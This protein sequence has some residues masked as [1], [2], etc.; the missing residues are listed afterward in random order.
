M[1]TRAMYTFRSAD[2]SEEHHVYVH[3]D[4]YPTGAAE[5][6]VA[7]LEYAWPLPRYEA[8]EFAAAFVAANKS[9]Y[10]NQELELLRQ[11][12]TLGD[13]RP[14]TAKVG[15]E[16]SILRKRLADVRR[17]H[18]DGFSGGGVRLM[19][20]GKFEDVAPQDL[21]YRYIIQ[22]R[23]AS[24]DRKHHGAATQMDARLLVHAFSVR[25]QGDVEYIETGKPDRN[26]YR[27]WKQR[28]VPKSKQ[29][30]KET[31]LFTAPLKSG[32]TLK[33]KAKAWEEADRKAA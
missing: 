18:K 8:D 9:H 20:S 5:K 30:W 29:G 15:A 31:K 26:G 4:G 3:S 19:P 13:V 11:L 17:Y 21:E 12:E 27:T 1:S 23:Q 22:P 7:A 6:I 16:I 33:V 14:M 24:G 32:D 2:G 28:K 10:I 25:H